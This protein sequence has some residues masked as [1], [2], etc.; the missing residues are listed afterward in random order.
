M[1]EVL[2]R[3]KLA[4]LSVA[5]AFRRK[6]VRRASSAIHLKEIALLSGGFHILNCGILMMWFCVLQLIPEGG[7]EKT[8]AAGFSGCRKHSTLVVSGLTDFR[9][10]AK[11]Y[12]WWPWICSCTESQRAEMSCIRTSREGSETLWLCRIKYV[13]LW[14]PLFWTDKSEIY[15]LGIGVGFELTCA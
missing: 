1:K 3:Q 6:G 11:R 5:L 15:W 8:L 2:L 14:T 7:A 12:V 9:W 13:K 10:T 4:L